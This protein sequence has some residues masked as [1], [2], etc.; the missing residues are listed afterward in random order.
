MKTP[1]TKNQIC[2]LI[3]KNPNDQHK[4]RKLIGDIRKAHC[5]FF[6]IELNPETGLHEFICRDRTPNRGTYTH[7]WYK[8][9]EGSY[10]YCLGVLHGMYKNITEKEP[11]TPIDK[12]K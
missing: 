6:V 12:K 11:P 10:D 1:S 3:F 9:A 4:Y 2:K 5:D 7:Q 8:K